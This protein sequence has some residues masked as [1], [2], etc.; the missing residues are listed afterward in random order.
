VHAGRVSDVIIEHTFPLAGYS[1]RETTARVSVE[2]LDK[3]FRVRRA[4]KGLGVTWAAAVGAVFIPGLH[5][6]LVPALVLAGPIVLLWRLGQKELVREARAECP[7]CGLEQPLDLK[8]P[9]RGLPTLT[10]R[11]CQRPLARA[12]RQ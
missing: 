4:L 7:D 2:Q 12:R 10:C 3:P 1:G 5:F 11:G 6:V 8:G 9:W